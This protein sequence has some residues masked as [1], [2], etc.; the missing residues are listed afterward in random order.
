MD[1]EI[2]PIRPEIDRIQNQLDRIET[3]LDGHLERVSKLEQ[4][5][6]WLRGHLQVAT[7]IV[8]SVI[9][10]LGTFLWKLIIK[11]E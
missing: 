2:L 10:F 5:V 8:I 11:G 4:D 6:N 9:G 7:A 3:K 1:R